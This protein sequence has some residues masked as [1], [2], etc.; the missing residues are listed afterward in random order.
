MSREYERREEWIPFVRPTNNLNTRA[1][2]CAVFPDR[3]RTIPQHVDRHH[4]L[5]GRSVFRKRRH[6]EIK[7]LEENPKDRRHVVS[8]LQFQNAEIRI[9]FNRSVRIIADP[10]N[11]GKPGVKILIDRQSRSPGR[12]GETLIVDFAHRPQLPLD[13]FPA[14]PAPRL[15]LR[16]SEVHQ[17]FRR[18]KF[19][20]LADAIF[21]FSLT[22]QPNL[23]FIAVT[24]NAELP[25]RVPAGTPKCLQ[26]WRVEIERLNSI[27]AD[28]VAV[29]IGEHSAACP[30][31]NLCR[32]VG[33]DKKLLLVRRPFAA[34]RWR[35]MSAG[36]RDDV[37]IGREHIASFGQGD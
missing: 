24:A 28:R 12:P 16:G 7:F 18:S 2:K 5:D 33:S 32:F 17:E 34:Q 31:G 8:E 9:E 36:I 6:S 30:G 19:P 10:P 14:E 11:F 15:A 3:G 20:S 27:S 21:S 13:A 1:A 4:T 29:R 22:F 25:R 23:G 35:H 37:R 26:V